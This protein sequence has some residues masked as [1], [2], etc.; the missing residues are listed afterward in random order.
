M[1][2]TCRILAC[3]LF[4]AVSVLPL[5]AQSAP[6]STRSQSPRTPTQTER[7]LDYHSDIALQQDGTFLVRETIT[8]NSRGI[9]IRHGIYRDFPTRYTDR[10]GRNY[11]VGFHFLSAELDGYQETSRIEDV[12][13]GKRI[14]LG[15]Q[16]YFVSSGQHTYVIAYTT[17]RQ[18]GFFPDHDEMYW[19]VTGNGW[20]FPIDHASAA[21]TLPKNITDSGVNLDGFTG[22]L[23]SFDRNLTHQQ[24][25]DGTCVF[26]TTAPL[27]VHDGLSIVL[28]WQKGLIAP[29][30]QQQQLD[31]FLSDN[32]VMLLS[33]AGLLIL[34]LY[35]V[36]VWFAVGRDPARGVVMPLYEPPSGLSPAATRYL[37]RMAFDNKTFAAA[38]LDMAVRG[39]LTVKEQAGSYTLYRTKTDLR[40]LTPDEMQLASVLFDTRNELWLHNENHT[41]IKSGMTALKNWLKLNEEKIYFFTNSRY[42]IPAIILS[43]LM[44]LGISAVQSTLSLFASAFLSVWLSIW[45]LA[46]A[47]LVIGS[48]S[49][50]KTAFT[51]PA[52]KTLLAGKALM[53]T[54]FSL[55]FLF[56]EGFGIWMLAKASS[57]F[58]PIFLV[59]CVLLHILFHYLLKAPT[60]AGRRLM[61]Q[62]DGFKLFLGAVDGDRLNR[63]M[64]P[65][66]TPETFEKFLPYALALDLEQ[67]WSQKFS[68]ELGT[69]GTAPSTGS[70]AYTPSF[71]SGSNWNGFGA[72][73]FAGGFSSSFTSAVS[74]S[75]SAPGSSSG[76]SGG[77]G[78]GGGGGGGGGW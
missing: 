73:G 2:K 48:A 47:G 70:P 16:K 42:S 13:N 74:S 10:F 54:L 57:I 66:K 63:V 46:C 38:I 30:T 11:V 34:L 15:D 65:D 67:A 56:G 59:A 22:P 50:W 17:N 58:I 3:A 49:S 40:V 23:H 72:G 8:V 45:S 61:D 35:Y 37:V 53:T 1:Q 21:V 4:A 31:Y 43:I 76:S 69:A 6:P 39:Y 14:Y 52:S 5:H 78:G 7:I 75:A 77:S 60:F 18:L 19:N 12:T 32:S 36:C 27:R 25:P 26:E 9:Q 33:A 64:P 28:S 20:G 41:V 55:P 62:V 29:P 68:A 51:A 44:L 24:Q 71:Y